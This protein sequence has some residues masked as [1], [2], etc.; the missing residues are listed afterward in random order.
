MPADPR[1]G[2]CSAG[3]F[4]GRPAAS[5][6]PR[7]R[8]CAR[9]HPPGVLPRWAWPECAG[10]FGP[11]RPQLRPP[12][13]S[14]HGSTGPPFH[15]APLYPRTPEQLWLPDQT[16][17]VRIYLKYNG[18]CFGAVDPIP[19]CVFG[20]GRR[21]VPH[22]AWQLS[23][24]SRGPRVQPTLTPSTPKGESDPPGARWVPQGR[25]SRP[26]VR[27]HSEVVPVLR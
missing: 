27:G 15:D 13:P 5:E 18:R 10:W 25:P 12:S 3:T 11:S 7:L 26:R 19:T 8:S 9:P 20:G 21:E 6:E 14:S 22:R 16:Q 23:D 4:G 2:P 1:G 17:N 24:T